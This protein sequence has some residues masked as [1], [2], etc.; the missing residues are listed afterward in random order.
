MKPK[1]KKTAAVEGPKAITR[2]TGAMFKKLRVRWDFYTWLCSSVPANP[3]LIKA[4]LGAREP[5]VKPAGGRSTDEITE[6][7]FNTLAIQQPTEEEEMKK[8]LLIFQRVNGKLVMRADTVR[9]HIK[10]CARI[11]GR[12]H[13]GKVSGEMPWASRLINC[14]YPDYSTC[15]KAFGQCWI[16]VT[17]KEGR[18]FTEPH[19]IHEKPVLLWSGSALKAFE[20]VND[21]R[22]EFTLTVLGGDGRGAIKTEDFE[23][24]FLYGGV[25][26]YAGERSDGG[27]KYMSAITEAK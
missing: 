18:P 9:A 22:M 26:G 12:E 1:D 5:A 6:E 3:D 20:Y 4:W 7:V 21:A 8:N 17:D 14:T 23:K 16:P 24:L 19:G 15:L 10:D 25:H 13:V 11:I 2:P 27:G